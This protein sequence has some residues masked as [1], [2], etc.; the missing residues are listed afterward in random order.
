MHLEQT[1]KISANGPT[2]SAIIQGY[3][4]MAQWQRSAK[5]HLRFIQQHVDI[6]VTTV[7]HAHVYGSPSCE[8][9]FGAA[10]SLQPELRNKLQVVTKCGIQLVEEAS[11]KNTVNHY[12]ASAKAIMK[13]VETSLLRLNIESIDVLLIHRPDLLLDADEV[14]DTFNMLREQGKVRHF[15]VSNFSTDQFLLL[16]S[17]LTQGLVTNQVEVNPLNMQ[18]IESGVLDQMQLLRIR[19]M[20]WSCLAGGALFKSNNSRYEPLKKVLNEIVEET[21]VNSIDQVLYAW[22]M[23]LPSK[24]LPIIGSGNIERV[25]LAL[26]A[27]KLKLTHEQWYRIW[28]AA[29]GHGVP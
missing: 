24:P 29:K 17:R 13:S 20:A 12:N 5:Q 18:S 22:A 26:D 8:S 16:Q 9:L 27:L 6:G 11:H 21:D 19:P 1:V 23:R 25:Q 10:L 2:F 15:G 7:D 4:R 28:V 14:A 3:W